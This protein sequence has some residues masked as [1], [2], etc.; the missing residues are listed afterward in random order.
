MFESEN[1]K[2]VKTKNGRMVLLSKCPVCDSVKSKII[3]EQDNIGL[4]IIL[5]IK[6]PLN[7]IPLVGPLLF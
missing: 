7:K 4:L 6:T 5:G 1:R 3:K 2:V